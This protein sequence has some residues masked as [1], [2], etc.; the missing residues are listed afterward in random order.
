MNASRSDGH[1]RE[2]G[3]GQLTPGAQLREAREKRSLGIDKV[4]SGLNLDASIIRAL[5]SDDSSTLPAPIFV[6]GYLRS[7]A[8]LLGLPEDDIVRD[9]M[10]Q[11]HEPPPLHVIRVQDKGGVVWLPSFR[12]LRNLL[13][14][15]VLLAAGWFAWP[16]VVDY[17][18]G[19]G[20][21]DDEP[22]PGMLQLPL[23][24]E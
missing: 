19:Q 15:A 13:L 9:Y 24:G 11:S 3:A 6:Q 16:V 18:E 17:I 14:L 4:A 10:R 23:P 12:L 5:E 7:Y 1:G 20:A 22:E 2:Q 8:R 21:P